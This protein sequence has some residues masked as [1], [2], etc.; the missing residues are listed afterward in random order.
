MTSSSKIA[1]TFSI[2]WAVASIG[3]VILLFIL[4]AR[5]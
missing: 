1:F 3:G 5:S 4:M 2:M